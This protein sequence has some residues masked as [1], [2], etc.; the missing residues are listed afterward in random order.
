MDVKNF[1]NIVKK[2]TD[3]LSQD[4]WNELAD[5]YKEFEKTVNCYKYLIA[6]EICHHRIVKLQILLSQFMEDNK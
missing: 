2:D 5:A 6:N 4:Q 3:T 1:E